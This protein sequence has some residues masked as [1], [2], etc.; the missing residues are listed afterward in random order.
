MD[1]HS[2]A[3]C[4]ALVGRRQALRG[5]QLSTDIVGAGVFRTSIENSDNNHEFDYH[6][7]HT[8]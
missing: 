5:R 6:N 7:E 8:R 2:D 4:N 3:H 1:N